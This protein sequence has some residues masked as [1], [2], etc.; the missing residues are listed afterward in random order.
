MADVVPFYV[1]VEQMP[2]VI[3]ELLGP[4]SVST[5]HGKSHAQLRK[6]INPSFTPKA[7]AM[8]AKRLVELASQVCADMADAAEP[9]GEDGM[10]KFAFKVSL[11]LL[12]S[13]LLSFLPVSAHK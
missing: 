4:R 13:Q 6:L 12:L 1:D 9:K 7:M 11:S 10:K 5:I 3:R 2:Y 8:H